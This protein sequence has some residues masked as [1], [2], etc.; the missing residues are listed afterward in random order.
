ML[1]VQF[2]ELLEVND[3]HR[4]KVFVELCKVGNQLPSYNRL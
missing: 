4:Q 2:E 1:V 3:V